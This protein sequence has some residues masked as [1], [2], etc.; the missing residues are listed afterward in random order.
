M[1]VKSVNICRQQL[2]AHFFH[3]SGYLDTLIG[4]LYDYLRPR[5]IH[6]NKIDILSELCVVMNI[7]QSDI[8]SECCLSV[9]N[10]LLN[11][12]LSST[13]ILTLVPSFSTQLMKT[14]IL[15]L[16]I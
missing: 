1:A 6:E 4:Y 5:I 2:M 3:L 8:P 12:D 13:L 10:S 11:R 16:D 15:H 7:Q 9:V 14:R